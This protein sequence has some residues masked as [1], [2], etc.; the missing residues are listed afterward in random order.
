MPAREHQMV[1]HR[2]VER[3]GRAREPAGRAAIGLA[4]LRVAARMIVSKDDTGASVLGRVGDDFAE[5]KGGAGFVSGVAR[6]MH[7]ARLV[8][9]MGDPQVLPGGIAVGEAAG[10]KLAGGR[11]AVE[12]KREFGTLISHAASLRARKST[13]YFN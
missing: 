13:D 3:F 6:Q 4:R 12:L 7:A 8:V 10:K 1:E 11:Q 5:W 2:A 9:D